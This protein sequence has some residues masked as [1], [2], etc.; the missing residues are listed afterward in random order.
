MEVSEAAVRL[1][2]AGRNFMAAMLLWKE[3]EQKLRDLLPPMSTEVLID[4]ASELNDPEE[5]LD[6]ATELL[7]RLGSPAHAPLTCWPR[8]FQGWPFRSPA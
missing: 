8:S 5:G 4:L 6:F 3:A 2:V 1:H 7:S